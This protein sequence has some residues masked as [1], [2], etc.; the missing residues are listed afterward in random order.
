MPAIANPYANGCRINAGDPRSWCECFG[1][2]AVGHPPALKYVVD[3][4]Q[5][6][7]NPYNNVP[8]RTLFERVTVGGVICIWEPVAGQGV[9]GFPFK[10]FLRKG[11]NPSDPTLW[12][13]TLRIENPP[14]CISTEIVWNPPGQICCQDE[15]ANLAASWVFF[16]CSSTPPFPDVNVWPVPFDF[17]LADL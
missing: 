13:W 7:N 15:Y 1:L 9:P 17:E 10:Y 11:F 3:F 14:G 12:V 4:D 8:R 6:T 16:L 2:C 5:N